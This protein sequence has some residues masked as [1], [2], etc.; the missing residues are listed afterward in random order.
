MTWTV[1]SSVMPEYTGRQMC[2]A[3]RCSAGA[4][5]CGA[6][7]SSIPRLYRQERRFAIVKSIEAPD[8]Q[9]ASMSADALRKRSIEVTH[10]NLPLWHIHLTWKVEFRTRRLQPA[11]QRAGATRAHRGAN[12][13][14]WRNG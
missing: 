10:R 3:H 7:S 8:F 13:G 9:V 1:S 12:V 2:L 14:P 5:N 6:A 11:A 4:R